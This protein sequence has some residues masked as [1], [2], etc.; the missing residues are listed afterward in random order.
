MNMYLNAIFFSVNIFLTMWRFSPHISEHFEKLKRG[1]IHVDGRI[2]VPKLPTSKC[3]LERFLRMINSS[4]YL[5][6]K[7]N[8]LTVSVKRSGSHSSFLYGL[9]F[10]N[11]EGGQ[12]L[13]QIVGNAWFSE[14]TSFT[15]TF[16]HELASI[17]KNMLFYRSVAYKYTSCSFLLF[18]FGASMNCHSSVRFLN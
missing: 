5:L 7:S 6:S 9:P 11:M 12:K 2:S 18:C 4:W 8:F 13:S 15:R 17:R 14:P 10:V 3:F 1:Q 16:A